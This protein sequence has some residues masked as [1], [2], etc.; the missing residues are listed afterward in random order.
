MIKTELS[1]MVKPN[2]PLETQIL[3]DPLFIKAAEK[4]KIS[5]IQLLRL[6]SQRKNASFESRQALEHALDRAMS[7]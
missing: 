2:S 1:S 7:N 6:R 4:L 5:P 3:I